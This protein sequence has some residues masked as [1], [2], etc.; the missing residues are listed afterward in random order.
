M[1]QNP[2][3]YTLNEFTHTLSVEMLLDWIVGVGIEGLRLARPVKA[4]HHTV[5][6]NSDRKFQARYQSGAPSVRVVY[7]LQV[8]TRKVGLENRPW[9][10]SHCRQLR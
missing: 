3:K 10:L 1:E 4:S 2:H 5:T 8:S 6:I 9:D 7:R